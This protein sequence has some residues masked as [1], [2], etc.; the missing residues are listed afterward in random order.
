MKQESAGYTTDETSKLAIKYGSLAESFYENKRFLIE[1]GALSS[2]I[3]FT[4]G[5]LKSKDNILMRYIKRDC[6]IDPNS[7]IVD[8]QAGIELE[9]M[10]KRLEKMKKLP[11]PRKMLSQLLDRIDIEEIEL[12]KLLED[13][14]K[15]DIVKKEKNSFQITE[16]GVKVAYK[17]TQI[18][19]F[20][21]GL[22]KNV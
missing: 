7:K 5:R 22:Y 6:G 18:R 20:G 12:K 2:I 10:K 8:I 4:E 14:E 13:A 1:L 16:L 11:K 21:L 19:R 17:N 15:D 3:S 9:K